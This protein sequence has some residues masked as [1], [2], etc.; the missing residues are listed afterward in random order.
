M[1]FLTLGIVLRRQL[2]GKTSIGVAH[3]QFRA[4]GQRRHAHAFAVHIC[5][6]G[7][8]EIVQYEDITVVTGDYNIIP[9]KDDVWKESA[10]LDDALYQPAVR[11]AYQGL[12]NLGF[13]D[14]WMASHSHAEWIYRA[15]V[16]Y[17]G[18]GAVACAGVMTL[19]KTLPTIVSAFRE[20]VKSF[21]AGGEK[22]GAVRT[23][24]DLAEKRDLEGRGW[25]IH[26]SREV[27]ATPEMYRA[28]IQ[29]SR[30]E[31][32]CAKRSC[33][34]LQNAWVSDR[35]LCYLASGKPVVLQDTGPSSFLTNGEGMFRFSTAEQA[36]RAFDVING[37]YEKH[38]R[39]AR[40]IAERFFD[41]KQVGKEILCQAL[42]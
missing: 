20:S 39:A 33:M 22:G 38:S 28:Y 29:R 8:R 37:D 32:S 21:G 14:A 5:A 3:P 30:G 24:R 15:Y 11:Q 13:T 25:R 4:M 36:A 12:K 41:A 9:T 6:V 26:H 19:I 17:I 31:F 27:A 23:E 1:G 7:T 34:E 10:W 2:F 18:A 42:T 35:T 16:R 40:R